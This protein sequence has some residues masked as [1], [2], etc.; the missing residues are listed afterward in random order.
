MIKQKLTPEGVL[1]NSCEATIVCCICLTE[2][3]PKNQKII[4]CKRCKKCIHQE[5]GLKWN[6]NCVYCRN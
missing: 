6:G 5:C 1:N 3:N 2:M 4:Q